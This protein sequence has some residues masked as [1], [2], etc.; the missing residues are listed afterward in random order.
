MQCPRCQYENPASQRFC[1]ECGA[2]QACAC[3]SC[4]ASNPPGQKFCGECGTALGQADGSAKYGTPQSYTPR[5]LAEK[6]LASKAALEGERKQVTVLFADLK[7]SMELLADRDPEDARKILDP[8]LERMM[9]AVHRYEGTVNQV[10]GDGV[11]ALFGAPL[12]HEDHGVRA[13]YAALR[14]QDTVGRYGEEVLRS[15]GARVQI[16][17]G[18]NSGDVVVRAIGS[19]LHMDYTAVGQTTH[20]AARMEQMAAPG[21]ILLA[22]ATLRLAEDY[23]QVA[24]QGLVPVKGLPDPV[25]IYLLTGAVARTR[26]QA[27]VVRGLTT[28]VGRDPEIEQMRRALTLARSGHGQLV[29]VVGEPGVGKS[30]LFHEFI[31]PLRDQGWLI[32][33]AGSVSYGRATSYLPVINLIKTYCQIE[34]QDGAPRIHEKLTGKLL[35][36]DQALEPTLPAFLALLDLPVDDAQWQA[37]DP[38]QRRQRTL[39][40]C[41]RLFLRESQAQPLLLVFEDLHWIDSETQALLES[42]VE[43]LPNARL[44]LLVNYRPE[45]QHGWGSKTYYAQLRIDPLPPASAVELLT[46]LLGDDFALSR[47]KRLLVERSEGNP[48]FL[49]ESVRTLVETAVLSGER[50]A[51]HL[52]SLPDSLEIPATAQAIVAARIDRLDSED[53]RLLQSASVVGKDVSIT[54]LC[55]IAGLPAPTLH[56]SL[57][58]LQSAEFLYEVRSFPAPE[59][60]FKHAVTHDVAYGSLLQDRR[61]DLHARLVSI[62][63]RLHADRLDEHVEQLAYHSF[64][65]AQWTSAARYLH[66]AGTRSLYRA[67]YSA[68]SRLLEQTLVALQHLDDRE[69]SAV[70]SIDVRLALQRALFSLGEVERAIPHLQAAE[71]S[72]RALGDSL[73]LNRVLGALAFALLSNGELAR[74]LPLAFEALSTAQSPEDRARAAL[75]VGQVQYALGAYPLALEAFRQSI[76]LS[77]TLPQTQRSLAGS[78]VS[79]LARCSFAMTSA[80]VGSFEE[81]QTRA[82]EAIELAQQ[83][84][85]PLNTQAP[86]RTDSSWNTAAALTYAG[87]FYLRRGN[88]AAALQILEPAFSLSHSLDMVSLGAPSGGELATTY[89][90]SG[91][92]D[93]AKRVLTL[94]RVMALSVKFGGWHALWLA[95]LAEGF[96]AAG[97]AEDATELATKALTLASDQTAQGYQAYALRILGNTVEDTSESASYY[98]RSLKLAETLGMRP[99]IAHCHLGLGKLYRRTGERGPAREHLTS[100]TTMYREMDMT[101]WLEQAEA[102]MRELA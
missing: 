39:D 67:A 17:V 84:E 49:E 63:E 37:L 5:H 54:L 30:R 19:D 47:L 8:V 24:S 35:A 48:F 71:A 53:K 82:D 80:D 85:A 74:A 62:I 22:P 1:G 44:L 16:R 20:L 78:D 77:D 94:A 28:F 21:T 40:A 59:F 31:R 68:A 26:L 29:A 87:Y 79:V 89:A 36:L 56:A 92:L 32:L 101:Y 81:G 38:P 97:Q 11:M 9:E 73:R 27:G 42:L 60:S 12:A 46:S 52:T 7:G 15:H 6:I 13:C 95:C 64:R 86:L 98:R 88:F 18:L 90:M 57:E 102:E 50:G 96:A 2:R 93:D 70:T 58:R 41:K 10:M 23:I 65:G 34:S 66:E 99:L 100:A 75:R 83:A 43:S 72:A 45:Y 3:P 61:L 14:M 76:E 51:Y 4:S 25:D 69:H 33:E 55:E 91:R